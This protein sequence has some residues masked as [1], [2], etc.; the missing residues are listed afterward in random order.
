[1]ANQVP[2]NPFITT[3]SNVG[4]NNSSSINETL[5]SSTN[6][7]PT[8]NILG[9]LIGAK[10]GSVV[11]RH[12]GSS[13]G[14]V[15]H[16]SPFQTGI[17][18]RFLPNGFAEFLLGNSV[19]KLEPGYELRVNETIA[20]RRRPELKSYRIKDQDI[21][22][23]TIIILQQILANLICKDQDN[24]QKLESLYSL[25][26]QIITVGRV[27][28]IYPEGMV[29]TA[30]ISNTNDHS[31]WIFLGYHDLKD[32]RILESNTTESQIQEAMNKEYKF[33]ERILSLDA[34]MKATI[35]DSTTPRTIESIWWNKGNILGRKAIFD[36][37]RISVSI[38]SLKPYEDT[39]K[40]ETKDSPPEDRAYLRLYTEFQNADGLLFSI[41]G[42]DEN[43]VIANFKPPPVGSGKNSN[44]RGR[45]WVPFSF[46]DDPTQQVEPSP[47]SSDAT[48]VPPA[49]ISPSSV[50]S[51]V[52]A[53]SNPVSLGKRQRTEEEPQGNTE[54]A[55]KI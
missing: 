50:D 23:N 2:S 33:L 28:A 17:L 42:Y 6:N 30:N 51:F 32:I 41:C 13:L 1:M 21:H 34:G 18:R 35:D 52:S 46:F 54:K 25:N 29:L 4:L 22:P 20:I 40:R 49:Q 15:V 55:P 19:V 47:T 31:S 10:P 38:L 16:L 7:L 12:I 11:E 3:A 53:P 48:C 5:A 43:G 14:D 24:T 44:S 45:C 26:D 37:G 36:G 8:G 27:V 9:I 39:L